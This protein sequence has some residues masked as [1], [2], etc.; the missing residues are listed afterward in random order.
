MESGWQSSRVNKG[1][2]AG[3]R[4]LIRFFVLCFA[5][6]C[7]W[8]AIP[9]QADDYADVAQL[10]KTGKAADAVSRADQ[11]LSSQPKDAQMRFLRGVALA[12]S[13]KLAEAVT[14]F[15]RL[16]EEFPDVPE[17]FNNLAVLYAQ[18]GQLERARHTLEAAIKTHPSYA[19]AY[20]NLGDVY[21][22]LAHQAYAKALQV[23]GA[24]GAA[25]T[26]LGLIRDLFATSLARLPKWAV[27]AVAV[28]SPPQ[29]SPQPAAANPGTQKPAALT[30]PPTPTPTPKPSPSTVASAPVAAATAAPGSS[31][32]PATDTSTSATAQEVELAVRAWAAAWASKDVRSYLAAYGKDFVPPG[33]A[34]RAAWEAERRQRI[35]TKGSISVRLDGL[36]ISVDGSRATA[37]FRQDYKSGGLSVSSRKTLELQRA[38]DKWKITRESVGN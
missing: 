6:A 19:T 27:P 34:S 16:T 28:A 25:S 23:D 20:D 21:A 3:A 35:T 18:Q 4:S 15:S 33:K 2:M 17:P 8:L 24:A 11:F 12:E 26:R 5:L 37:R 9:A 36:K 38:G 22:R 31:K 1:D 14:V 10:T 29:A 13:G 30:T 7:G 32:P